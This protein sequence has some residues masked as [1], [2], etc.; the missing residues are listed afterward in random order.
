MI[1]K[2][3]E[4][5]DL[6]A[7][8]RRM[9]DERGVRY[10]VPNSAMGI[11]HTAYKVDGWDVSVDSV[12]DEYLEVEMER[13]VDTPEQAIAVT[14]GNKGVAG[15]LEEASE[16]RTENTKLRDLVSRL[17][18]CVKHSKCDHCPYVEEDCDF[19]ADMREL[20]IDY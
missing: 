9:L 6:T 12:C 8:L 19:E 15:T 4:S 5:I 20:G 2:T 1:N 14:L 13:C 7:E 11:V 17:H 10:Q 16:L 18:E 3:D